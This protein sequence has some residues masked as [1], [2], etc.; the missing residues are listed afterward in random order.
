MGKV[1]ASRLLQACELLLHVH[2]YKFFC[3]S[4]LNSIDVKYQ[5]WKL[6]SFSLTTKLPSVP[7]SK[8]RLW[9]DE[10][11]G[12]QQVERWLLY[13][14]THIS[15]HLILT[16]SEKNPQKYMIHQPIFHPIAF[17]SWKIKMKIYLYKKMKHEN[18]CLF[19]QVLV[20]Q[21]HS[22]KF[23]QMLETSK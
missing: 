13:S 20:E 19:I 10:F 1:N 18:S 12:L 9:L 7:Q 5:M 21:W 22:S 17:N 11:A 15:V 14:V 16:I 23:L 4:R 8:R 6:E 2:I 3:F